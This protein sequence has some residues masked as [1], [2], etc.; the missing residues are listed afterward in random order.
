MEALIPRGDGLVARLYMTISPTAEDQVATIDTAF[1]PPSGECA[2]YLANSQS[3]TPS[4]VY[5]NVF[6]SL[7]MHGDA[8]GNGQV[9]VGDCVYLINYVFKG[10]RPPIPSQAGDANT[11][12]RINVGDVVYIINYVFKMGP[13]P[14]GK[15]IVSTGSV[16]YTLAKNPDGA[17]QLFV[18]T[19]VPLGGLQF[20]I[21]DPLNFVTI[22]DPQAGNLAD[23]MTVYQANTGRSHRF[24]LVDLQGTGIIRA[25]TGVAFKAGYKGPETIGA[26]AVYFFDESGNELPAKYGEREM[27][28]AMPVS[29][30]LSQNY[31]N[32]FNPVTTINYALVKP[33]KVELA[34]FNVLGQRVK[35]LVSE[36]QKPGYHSVVWDGTDNLGDK[37][38]TGIYFYRLKAGEFTQSHKMALI[39]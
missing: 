33:V 34:V 10:Q 25:G 16:Y 35:V 39:K 36:N 21:V 11:D 19:D 38:A 7:N 29:F 14:N 32:P 24:G 28:E 9:N 15:A 27:S 13:P 23:N 5:G 20:D 4:F 30:E 1:F 26:E 6:I 37:V 22:S 3:V 17:M 31:P 8:D 2:L 18:D 12:T